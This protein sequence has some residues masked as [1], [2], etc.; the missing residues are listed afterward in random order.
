MFGR[1]KSRVVMAVAIGAAALIAGC[2]SNGNSSSD[3]SAPSN[4]QTAATSTASAAETPADGGSAPAG[5]E[6]P[7]AGGA[8]PSAE[9]EDPAP[10]GANPPPAPAPAGESEPAAPAELRDPCGLPEAEIS[11][12][13]FRPD[14][15]ESLTGTDGSGDKSCRWPSLMGKS[16][17]TIVSSR[18]SVQ[19]LMDSGSYVE[20]EPV[21]AG[22][23]TGQQYR[24]AQDTNRIGCYVSLP[25]PDALVTII[26]RRLQPE[27]PEE[28][29]AQAQ[30][31]AAT[32]SNYLP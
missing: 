12:L 27:A 32:V 3:R 14:S 13:G 24:A 28:P 9:G 18:K 26:T 5:S 23:R 30:R 4:S 6:N 8:E 11:K 20:F 7:G 22:E 17:V 2:D 19:D 15:K 31:I 10:E 29:C 16:E 1:E 21:T 25:V